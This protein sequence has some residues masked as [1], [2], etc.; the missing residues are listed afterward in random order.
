MQYFYK[1]N[2]SILSLGSSLAMLILAGCTSASPGVSP[3]SDTSGLMAESSRIG[4]NPAQEFQN[5]ERV[6]ILGYDQDAMEPFISV[7]GQY[8]LFNNLNS[9]PVNTNLLYATRIDDLTFQYQGEI[10]GV[11]T[12]ELE[13]T[14]TMDQNNRLYFISVANYGDRFSTI[15]QGNFNAGEVSNVQLVENI[16]RERFGFVNFDV[17]TSIDGS[18]LYFVDSWFGVALE[19]PKTANLVLAKRNGSGFAVASNSA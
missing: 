1:P 12:S 8:L 10:L 4:S 15:Y 14:P 11:N 5:P 13:G 19:G 7:D 2:R 3:F 17:E 6:T 18:E 9:A 16:S